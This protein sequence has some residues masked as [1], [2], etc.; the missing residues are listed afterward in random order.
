[1]KRILC[2]LIM[3][4]IIPLIVG[5]DNGNGGEIVPTPE[6]PV[7]PTGPK[8]GTY[9]RE[10]PSYYE[11]GVPLV[12]DAHVVYFNWDGF[13]RYYYDELVQQAIDANAPTLKRLLTEGVFFENLRTALPSITN[14]CQ[15][16]I[17]TGATSSV[18]ENVYRYYDESANIVV[19]QQRDNKNKT[20][21]N[22]VIEAEMS[23]ASVRHYLAESQLTATDITK[24][25]VGLDSTNPKLI[26]RGSAKQGDHFARFEQL[27]RLVKGESL[28]TNGSGV[29]VT[30]LPRF[31]MF[32]AD[33][34]DAIGHNEAANYGYDRA[35]T[36]AGRMNNVVTLLKEMDAKLGEFLQVCKD[37]GIYDKMT[38]FLTTD[39]GMNGFGAESSTT[40][41]KYAMSKLNSLKTKLKEVNKSWELELV[42]ADS[43]PKQASTVVAVGANLNVQLTFRKGITDEALDQLKE[44]LLEEEYIGAVKTRKELIEDGYWVKDTDMIIS[45]SERYH[46]SGNALT[47]YLARAQHDSLNDSANRIPGWIWGKGIKENYIY[48]GQAFNYDFGVTMAACL[49]L[50]IPNANGIVLDIFKRD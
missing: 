26:A 8:K 17:I 18:T 34:L 13:A 44:I 30:T 9:D 3:L 11:E 1:M 14:P 38:F 20:I 29:K 43:T 47:M 19:Q 46:F 2:I 33:D 35:L 42:A 48:E 40:G 32:Y 7:E 49:G 39:H 4:I 10:Y 50:T 5:C 45:P 31:I 37:E 6:P 12:E 36:E 23:I 41:T 15:N 25:Y 27:I 28:T 21:V 16:M 22:M 24:L